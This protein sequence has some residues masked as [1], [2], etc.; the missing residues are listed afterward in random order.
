[1]PAPYHPIP[2]DVLRLII[3]VWAKGGTSMVRDMLKRAP[4]LC[5]PPE[6]GALLVRSP[7]RGLAE[8]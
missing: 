3:T 8:P 5:G 1:M 4:L 2:R 6:C 7:S